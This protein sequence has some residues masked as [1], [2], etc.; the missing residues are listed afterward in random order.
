MSFAAL[1]LME[2]QTVRRG[3]EQLK[4]IDPQALFV[5]SLLMRLEEEYGTRLSRISNALKHEPDLLKD[6]PERE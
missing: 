2:L 6:Q 1:T 3:L 4:A 5:N